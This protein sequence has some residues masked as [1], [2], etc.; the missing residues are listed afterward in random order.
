MA[1]GAN[2]KIEVQKQIQKA[3]G[4]DY[5]GEIDK[6]LYVWAN[7]GGESVQIAISLT[8]PKNPVATTAS[9]DWD[10]D[11]GVA[12][13]GPETATSSFEPAQITDKERETV[14]E[15]LKRLGL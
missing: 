7:D 14:E 1:K 12:A 6:K 4:E 3:F 15:L 11:S 13:A 10:F 2:A 8:C 5:I 9:G